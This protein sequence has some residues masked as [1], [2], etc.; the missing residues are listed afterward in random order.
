MFSP[1]VYLSSKRNDA[2]TKYRSKQLHIHTSQDEEIELH[3]KIYLNLR[4]HLIYDWASVANVLPLVHKKSSIVLILV[5][6]NGRFFGREEV[7]TCNHYSNTPQ[8]LSK[9]NSGP[10]D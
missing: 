6:G 4:Q 7:H 5:Q 1:L 10:L 9:R 8:E 3:K 2:I